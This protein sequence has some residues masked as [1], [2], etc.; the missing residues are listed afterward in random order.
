MR[1]VRLLRPSAQLFVLFL[2]ATLSVNAAPKSSKLVAQQGGPAHSSITDSS[3]LVDAAGFVGKPSAGSLAS[4]F[5]PFSVDLAV[6]ES[7]PLPTSLSNLKITFYSGD[8][9]IDAPLVF[10]S[11]GQVNLQIP[12]E[13]AGQ[14]DIEAVITAFG[15][16]SNRIPVTLSTANPSLFKFSGDL[17]VAVNAT[18]GAIAHPEGSFPGFDTTPIEPGGVILLYASGLGAVDV[19]PAT[20]SSAIADGEAIRRVQ[21]PVRLFI[22]GVEQDVIFA[23]LAPEFVGVYQINAIVAEGTPPGAFGD[24][25]LRV[26]NQLSVDGPVLAVAG[27]SPSFPLPDFSDAPPPAILISPASPAG[28]A[29]VTVAVRNEQAT[30]IALTASGPGCGDFTGGQ[31]AGA[32]LTVTGTV[33][34]AG[35]CSLAAAVT[36]AD[37]PQEESSS[38]Q[39]QPVFVDLPAVEISG[40]L[41]VP[42]PPP[43]LRGDAG[44]VAIAAVEAPGSLAAGGAATVR[45]QP[46]DPSVLNRIAE[47]AV[48]VLGAGGMQG[49][50]RVRPRVEG[51]ALAFDVILPAAPAQA[52]LQ[53]EQSSAI[54]LKSQLI[55]LSGSVGAPQTVE[56]QRLEVP[57]GPIQVYLIWGTDTDVDLHVVEPGGTEIFWGNTRSESGG[58]LFLDSNS[59][60]VI[61]RNNTEN[62]SWPEGTQPPFGE[63]V[64][65]ANLWSACEHQFQTLALGRVTVC[66]ESKPLLPARFTPD[67]A[68]QSG[69][70]AGLEVG[71]FNF[72]GCD[73]TVSGSAFYEDRPVIVDPSTELGVL[74]EIVELPIRYAKVEARDNTFSNILA[75]GSTDQNG[76]FQLSFPEPDGGYIV[77]VWAEGGNESFPQRVI[78]NIGNPYAV[79]TDPAAFLHGSQSGLKL[80]ARAE[81]NQS[82]RNDAFGAA[83]AFNILDQGVKGFEVIRRHHKKAPPPLDWQWTRGQDPVGCNVDEGLATCFDT[84]NKRLIGVGSS[85][86]YDDFV[87]LLGMG[88]YWSSVYSRSYVSSLGNDL[89]SM[90]FALYAQDSPLVLSLGGLPLDFEAKQTNLLLA[91]LFYDLA[92]FW[93]L[94][95]DVSDAE[96][97]DVISNPGAVFSTFERLREQPGPVDQGAPGLDN[98]DFIIAYL[99]VNGADQT[100]LPEL[101]DL[102]GVQLW[103]GPRGLTVLHYDGVFSNFDFDLHCS[104]PAN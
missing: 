56:L 102:N 35:Q 4:W 81:V 26:G 33:G 58:E 63:Y 45:I 84:E 59:D 66:G 72:A 57:A 75:T 1:L 3:G 19:A 22:G 85:G 37:G 52:A 15:V 65:R 40:A 70:G 20:G 99:C 86:A 46:A 18:T 64:V 78:S 28:G 48:E 79:V 25:R 38:F 36:T 23:G 30:A 10:V 51:D 42:G 74:G 39:V 43:A 87:E 14:T 67:N 93:D 80:V 16:A 32:E 61:D 83:P 95:D 97:T 54:Q 24:V 41:F 13:L 2:A 9:V 49:T 68:N 76:R 90:F 96:P 47:V 55:G 7:I 17:A 82:D 44:A 62:I 91:A 103:G 21:A 31:G 69:A 34:A 101:V 8:L 6:A 77:Y 71:R 11:A 100:G 98:I 88:P 29:E 60:C 27:E 50:F 104:V 89:G 94:A 53:I 12:W 73:V 92:L 5:A